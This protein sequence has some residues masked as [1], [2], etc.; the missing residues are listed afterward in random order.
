MRAIFV[1]LKPD[2]IMLLYLVETA[3]IAL[4]LINTFLIIFF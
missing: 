1:S 2:A 4:Q 3:K